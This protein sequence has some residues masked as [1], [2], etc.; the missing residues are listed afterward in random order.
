MVD[1]CL[2]SVNALADRLVVGFFGLA[3]F[4]MRLPARGHLSR[5]GQDGL[6]EVI[7]AK[8]SPANGTSA[9]ITELM[10]GS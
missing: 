4:V 10:S 1:R 2:A 8:D 3:R 6:G 5:A 9:T 7:P